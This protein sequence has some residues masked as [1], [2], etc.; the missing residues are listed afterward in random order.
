MIVKVRMIGMMRLMRSSRPRPGARVFRPG[1]AGAVTAVLA[2]TLA[3]L[4]AGCGGGG[5]G[6]TQ[7][8]PVDP[9][10]AG[11]TAFE[12][13]DF[14]GARGHFA[15][16]VAADPTSADAKDGLGWSLLFIA[17]GATGAD[18]SLLAAVSDFDGAISLAPSSPDA[19]A[20]RAAAERGLAAVASSHDSLA[21]VSAD[22]ALGLSPA[23]Q[24]AHR[25]SIDWKDLRLIIADAAFA[26]GDYT[27]TNT[28]VVNL[29]GTAID[30]GA[31]NFADDMLAQLETLTGV[32]DADG[33]TGREAAGS[34]AD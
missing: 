28:E 31:P 4:A 5:A 34:P 13:G 10:V 12:S 21:I 19:Y 22:A 20:G 6:T 17:P 27:R 14:A 23:F 15:E 11:W 30:P 24:F 9:I 1:S 3:G 18:D 26:R 2:I 29:G 8:P 32:I 7:P 16:A 33:M 25:T